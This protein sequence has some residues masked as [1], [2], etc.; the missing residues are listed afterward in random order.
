VP[1]ALLEEVRRVERDLLEGGLRRALLS[2][3]AEEEVDAAARRAAAL[4]RVGTYPQPGP[5]RSH[6][7]PAV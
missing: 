4:I 7:W 6:P 5:G 3:L 1:P 2:L